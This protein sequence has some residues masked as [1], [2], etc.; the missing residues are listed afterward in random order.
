MK[1]FDITITGKTESDIELAID[2]VASKIKQGFLCGAD[3]NE[4]GSILYNSTGEY[5]VA[6]E[7]NDE[8]VCDGCGVVCDIDDSTRHN[9]L[10]YCPL[11][12]GTEKEKE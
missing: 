11:C 9:H 5:E 4:T 3:K 2:E 1:S 6:P 7:D 12:D 10:Y 8:F